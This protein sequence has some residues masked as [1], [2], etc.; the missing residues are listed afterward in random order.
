MINTRIFRVEKTGKPAVTFQKEEDRTLSN[1]QSVN[2]SHLEVG[3]PN[4]NFSNSWEVVHFEISLLK[5]D[6]TVVM[7]AT[8]I[9]GKYPG[10]EIMDR[11]IQTGKG[12][13]ILFEQ[14]VIKYK[15]GPYVKY[16]SLTATI[17]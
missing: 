5:K 10:K 13:K 16:G 2:Y 4:K 14:V 7:P 6:G 9:S 1:G 11:L 15:D 8:F 3:L 17:D 12:G